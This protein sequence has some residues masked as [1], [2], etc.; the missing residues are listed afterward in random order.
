M[1]PDVS[2]KRGGPRMDQ[3]DE[4]QGSDFASTYPS[5]A[6]WVNGYGWIEMGDDLPGIPQRSFV[7]A[8]DEGGLIWAGKPTY[9]TVDDALRALDEALGT[10]MQE[11]L[12]E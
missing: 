8:L 3:G 12:G 11:A 10:W 7:R 9:R 6:K 2:R 5:I 4:H 1:G